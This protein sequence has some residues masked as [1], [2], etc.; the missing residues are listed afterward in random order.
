M[1]LTMQNMSKKSINDELTRTKT[2]ELTSTKWD[3]EI[4]AKNFKIQQLQATQRS[5]LHIIGALSKSVAFYQSSA[6]SLTHFCQDLSNNLRASNTLMK[7]QSAK[8]SSLQKEHIAYRNKVEQEIHDVQILLDE[9][10]TQENK[11]FRSCDS[12]ASYTAAN[13][14][15]CKTE[16]TT[17]DDESFLNRI[18]SS[19]EESLKVRYCKAFLLNTKISQLMTFLLALHAQQSTALQAE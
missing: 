18:Y 10:Q 15:I 1:L 5:H 9:V 19:D 4:K 13:E 11:I 2:V 3:A 14:A 8:Y 12:S 16:N 17:T 7:N 6:H